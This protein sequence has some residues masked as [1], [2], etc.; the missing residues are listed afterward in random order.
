MMSISTGKG[1]DGS[2]DMIGGRRI[3][4]NHPLIECLGTIDELNA[5]LGDCKTAMPGANSR[6]TDRRR[7][8]EGIQKQLFTIMGIIAGSLAKAPDAK[9][10]EA[11]AAEIESKLP[12]FESFA[13]PGATPVSAK[14]HIARTVC[15]RAER[16]LAGLFAGNDI[17]AS[18]PAD[19]YACLQ[20]WFNRLSDLLFLMA[21]EEDS[22]A[23]I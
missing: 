18:V 1:D 21:Q 15:R 22:A 14:F 13:V 3:P 12:V 10:L 2:T 5:F 20:A 4:K 7:T 16:R 9:D 11:L 8:I 6:D 23:K 19:E 17:P